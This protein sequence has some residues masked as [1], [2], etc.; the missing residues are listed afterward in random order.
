MT[1]HRTLF[2]VERVQI[3][4]RLLDRV[5][6]TKRWVEKTNPRKKQPTTNNEANFEFELRASAKS[7]LEFFKTLYLTF[8]GLLYF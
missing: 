2:V 1:R 8:I 5:A 4:F 6:I 3:S 7:V